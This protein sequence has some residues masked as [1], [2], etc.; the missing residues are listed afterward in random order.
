[1]LFTQPLFPRNDPAKPLPSVT[2]RQV[3]S[4]AIHPWKVTVGRERIAPFRKWR[5]RVAPGPLNETI[6]TTDSDLTVTAPTA[7]LRDVGSFTPVDYFD[8][9]RALQT[10]TL[11]AYHSF[12]ASVLVAGVRPILPDNLLAGIPPLPLPATL[13]TLLAQTAFTQ[14]LAS[15]ALAERIGYLRLR[16]PYR[17]T[18]GRF[19]SDLDGEPQLR[20]AW[21]WLFRP[22][23]GQP[24]QDQLLVEQLVYWPLQ[25]ATIVEDF[26][27]SQII[28]LLES[29]DL[30]GYATGLDLFAALLQVQKVRWW[31][32]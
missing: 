3:K 25:A 16:P 10:E 23:N 7:D 18:A 17:T 27:Q 19:L 12:K 13:V 15:L 30:V 2:G 14:I 4:I 1:M 28:P 8:R 22:P 32:C 29:I 24:K 31:N 26:G 20:L 9:P 6:V 11:A 5:V 21:L